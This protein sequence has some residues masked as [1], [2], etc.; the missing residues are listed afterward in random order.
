[1]ALLA[2]NV[3]GAFEKRAPVPDPDPDHPKGTQP[4]CL[5]GFIWRQKMGRP[6]L[7]I[8]TSI[9]VATRQLGE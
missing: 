9:A 4:L 7:A 5:Q 2:R 1:M 6:P 8:L 3:S